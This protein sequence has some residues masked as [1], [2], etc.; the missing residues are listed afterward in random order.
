M[1]SNELKQKYIDI[2]TKI[3]DSKRL[4]KARVGIKRKEGGQRM[5]E[6]TVIKHKCFKLKDFIIYSKLLVIQKYAI[7]Q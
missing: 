6:I 1:L 4:Y 3:L 5:E 7:V 2:L